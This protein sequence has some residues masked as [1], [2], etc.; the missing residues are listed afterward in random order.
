MTIFLVLPFASP[1]WQTTVSHAKR[2]RAYLE[3]KAID[4]LKT[5]RNYFLGGFS[6]SIRPIFSFYLRVCVFES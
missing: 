4:E 3:W 6:P 5:H 1:R 2:K